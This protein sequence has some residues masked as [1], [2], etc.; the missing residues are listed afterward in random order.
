LENRIEIIKYL[1]FDTEIYTNIDILIQKTFED[2]IWHYYPNLKIVGE[3]D[4]KN[5]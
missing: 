3:E 2:I 4:T 1:K 5:A